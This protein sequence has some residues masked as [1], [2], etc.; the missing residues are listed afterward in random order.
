M[1]RQAAAWLDDI[2]VFRPGAFIAGQ[3]L[4]IN[5]DITLPGRALQPTFRYARDIRQRAVGF[6]RFRLMSEIMIFILPIDL[7]RAAHASDDFLGLSILLFTKSCFCFDRLI[8]AIYGIFISRKPQQ[9]RGRLI[10]FEV[11]PPEARYFSEG[12]LHRDG[13]H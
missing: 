11:L 12:R 1:L 7:P 5:A 13:A 2:D 10:L 9:R 4:I 6:S 3:P 8:M